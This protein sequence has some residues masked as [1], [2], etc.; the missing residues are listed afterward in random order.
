VI[1]YRKEEH[2]VVA[3]VLKR[4]WFHFCIRCFYSRESSDM[5]ARYV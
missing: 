3:L 4:F 5:F 1:N 2:F